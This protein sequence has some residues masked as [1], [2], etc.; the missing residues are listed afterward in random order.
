MRDVQANQTRYY[1]FDNQGTTQ[2]LTDSTGTVTDR[3]ASDAWGVQ[4]K[5]TG[6]SINRQWYIGRAGYYRQVDQSLD[7]VRARTLSPATASWLTADYGLL[8][9][10]APYRY[11]NNRAPRESDPAGHQNDQPCNAFVQGRVGGDPD[12]LCQAGAHD[13]VAAVCAK[14]IGKAS[15]CNCWVKFTAKLDILVDVQLTGIAKTQLPNPCTIQR[16]GLKCTFGENSAG[17]PCPKGQSCQL[18]KKLINQPYSIDVKRTFN[19]PQ[20][21]KNGDVKFVSAKGAAT[22]ELDW[23][24]CRTAQ[25]CAG[26]PGPSPATED[27]DADPS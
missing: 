24:Q 16:K 26:D 14:V 21:G 4:V 13:L 23:R 10:S 17:K 6:T 1:H 19:P 5:R 3:F 20:H 15:W 2:A 25:A 27:L 8:R 12:G 22:Y 11:V 9:D 7:Y 18:V